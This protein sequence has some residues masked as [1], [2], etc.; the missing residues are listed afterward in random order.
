MA[1]YTEVL[2]F[3]PD[4]QKYTKGHPVKHLQQ[5]LDTHCYGPEPD[6]F[7]GD[8][9]EQCLNLFKGGIGMT[10]DGLVDQ[11]TW[12]VLNAPPRIIARLYG[13]L[14]TSGNVLYWS[15]NN[16]GCP[17]IPANTVVTSCWAF[18]RANITNITPAY[19][20]GPTTDQ[21][22]GTQESF[23]IDLL[24]FFP[25]DGHYTVAVTVGPDTATLD[26]DIVNGQ[27]F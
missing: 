13:S 3:E 5:L 12:A 14:A 4:L 15:A 23:S 2:G 20:F 16:A 24:S 8:I 18:E 9:T 11:A 26:Y 1:Q 10:E 22:I 6:G 21:P 17:T 25:A 19:D 27:V 7:F